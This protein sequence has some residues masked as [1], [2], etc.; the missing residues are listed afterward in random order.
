MNTLRAFAE[1]GP[2]L[3][4]VDMLPAREVG[5]DFYDFWEVDGDWLMTAGTSRAVP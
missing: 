4:S 1:A 5:G 2:D 3:I